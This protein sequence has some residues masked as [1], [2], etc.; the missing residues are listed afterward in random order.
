MKRYL[1]PLLCVVSSAALLALVLWTHSR[2]AKAPAP[3]CTCPR[4]QPQR[5]RAEPLPPRN[6]WNGVLGEMPKK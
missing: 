1:G 2:A 5:K 4:L 6:L 3:A